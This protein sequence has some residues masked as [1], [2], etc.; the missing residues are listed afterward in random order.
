M[1]RN[2]KFDEAA[3]LDAAV[4]IVSQGGPQAATV[5]A[6]GSVIGASNGSIYHRFRSRDELL[7]R[8][9]LRTVAAFQ[10]Q[11]AQALAHAQPHQAALDAALSIPRWV[12]AQPDSA[13][14]L[15]LHRREDFLS[16]GWPAEMMQEAARLGQEA[17]AALASLA[18]RLFGSTSP[19]A[20][21][22]LGFAVVDIPYAAVRRHLGRQE[23][24]PPELDDLIEAACRA[25]IATAAERLVAAAPARRR[26]GRKPAAHTPASRV[27]SRPR[28]AS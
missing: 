25:A 15:L 13:R 7:G 4:Q 27:P 23:L 1:G 10:R 5:N 19:Q 3:I 14:V 28:S 2:A 18:V 17:E 16:G 12:R 26:S 21:A 6:I 8:L 20:L 22:A 9:W 11:F 24:P